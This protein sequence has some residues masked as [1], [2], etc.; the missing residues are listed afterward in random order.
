MVTRICIMGDS[1]VTALKLGWPL[2]ESEF[3]NT[4]PTF[5]AGTNVEWRNVGVRDGQITPH[6]EALRNQFAASSNGHTQINAGFDAYAV[7]GLGLGI[8]RFLSAALAAQDIADIAQ[9]HMR[10][11]LRLTTAANVLAMLRGITSARVFLLPAPYQP[12]EFSTAVTQLTR[13]VRSMISTLFL[14]ECRSLAR[15]HQVEFMPQPYSTVSGDLVTTKMEYARRET[16][17]GLAD[18]V[19]CNPQYGA[20]VLRQILESAVGDPVAAQ[21]VSRS[22]P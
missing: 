13:E 7:N 14:Q 11:K 2:I 1:H 3:A 21:Q 8:G 6:S 18:H 9:Q 17:A 22:A 10:K 12:A 20:L 5:F 4:E 16:R 15:D 19:H